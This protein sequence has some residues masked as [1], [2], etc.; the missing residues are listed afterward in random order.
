MNMIPIRCASPLR[1]LTLEERV[2][3][4]VRTRGTSC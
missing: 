2:E 4:N 1:K 3:E